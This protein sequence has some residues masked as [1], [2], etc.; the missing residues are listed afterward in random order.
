VS[1]PLAA[2]LRLTAEWLDVIRRDP[3]LPVEHLPPDWPA[4]RA[5]KLFRELEEAGREPAA[6]VAATLLDLQPDEHTRPA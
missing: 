1:D 3:R 5:Q 2:R 6:A 4:V